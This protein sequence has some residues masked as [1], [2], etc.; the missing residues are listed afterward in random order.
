MAID[1]SL[2]QSI[3]QQTGA[4]IMDVKKALEEAGGN[5]V[6][7]LELLKERG[8]KIAAKKQEE[9]SAQEGLVESYKHAGG[10]V[11]SMILL[12]CETD[13]V[14]KNDE[15]KELAHDIAMQ[16]AA[17]SP[18]YISSEDV[19]AEVLATEKE[20]IKETLSEE[21]LAKPADIL[22]KIIEGRVNKFYEE[23]CLMNQSFIKDDQKKV[24]DVLTEKIAKLGEKLEV[25]QISRMSI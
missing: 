11:G 6:E 4:G 1:T 13:F 21:D 3:R 5:E 15:F 16:V 14:A 9:R 23:V 22:E 18:L 2:I 20:N 24:I 7:A 8:Q 19:P 17:M 10:T 12:A 25:K